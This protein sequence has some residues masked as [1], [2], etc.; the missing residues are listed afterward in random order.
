LRNARRVFTERSGKGPASLDDIYGL[1]LV[2]EINTYD[3][4]DAVLTVSEKEADLVNDF[5]CKRSAFAVCDCE[6]LEASPVALKK[7]RGIVLVGCFRHTPNADA[8]A[9]LCGEILPLVDKRVL[10]DHPVQIVGD[11][12]TDEI[13]GHAAD[14]PAVRMVGWVP[15]VVPYVEHAR[16]TVLPLRYGA[17]TKRKLLQTLAI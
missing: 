14:L 13:R 7:R 12:L 5:L 8:V 1:E 15:S 3:M 11:G 17:G 10:A 6:S 2:R 9:Y 16:L 4:A